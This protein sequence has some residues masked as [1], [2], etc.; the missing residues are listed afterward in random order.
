[1]KHVLTTFA[2]GPLGGLSR[3]SVGGA[4]QRL[5]LSGAGGSER[6]RVSGGR[7]HDA[8]SGGDLP[9]AVPAQRERGGQA[10]VHDLRLDGGQRRPLLLRVSAGVLFGGCLSGCGHGVSE[11]QPADGLVAAPLRHVD[12]L[13]DLRQCGEPA[14]G[15]LVLLSAHHRPRARRLHRQRHVPGAPADLGG[16]SL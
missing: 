16:V 1:M 12:A 4:V 6:V 5:W 7:L 10:H 8:R 15:R 9:L 11:P 14:S 13:H 2:A 3:L